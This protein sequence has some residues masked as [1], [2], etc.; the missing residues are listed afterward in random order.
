MM[1]SHAGGKRFSG[2]LRATALVVVFF[3]AWTLGGLAGLAQA[4]KLSEAQTSTSAPIRE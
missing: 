2:S 3:F 1:V 4:A